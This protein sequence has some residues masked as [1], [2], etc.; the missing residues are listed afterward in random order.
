[1]AGNPTI[2][3]AAAVLTCALLSCAAAFEIG[4]DWT[5]SDCTSDKFTT[6]GQYG[7]MVTVP[8]PTV[9]TALGIFLYAGGA[10]N[11]WGFALYAVG[12]DNLPSTLLAAPG[13]AAS[14]VSAGRHAVSL[15]QPYLAAPGNY[16]IVLS[17]LKFNNLN[18][19]HKSVAGGSFTYSTAGF[20]AWSDPYG[21]VT[22]VT[23]N[24]VPG[25]YLVGTAAPTTSTGTTSTGT[26]STGT[27]STGTTSTG[28]T[29]TGTTSTGTTSTGTTST[30]VIIPG[31]TLTTNQRPI[32]YMAQN[33]ETRGWYLRDTKLPTW[34]AMLFNTAVQ[35]H[36]AKLCVF[37]HRLQ[38]GATTSTFYALPRQV[39]VV[40]Y[41][42]DK[43]VGVTALVAFGADKPGVRATKVGLLLN[44]QYQPASNKCTG[45]EAACALSTVAPPN[46]PVVTFGYTDDTWGL[47]QT[48]LTPLSVNKKG[49][50]VGIA[51]PN[52]GSTP[53]EVCINYVHI[54]VHY[55]A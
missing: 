20:F 30:G 8:T 22:I 15:D 49:F 46:D 10:A 16:Y 44:G 51:A 21:P 28:T 39:G 7:V 41:S 35:Q 11:L 38:P 14:D 25:L 26:T 23:N 34:P 40:P 18:I 27:T 52:T 24:V 9:V 6:T 13:N 5:L 2:F 48:A 43:V 29:S 45:S 32:A 17:F 54:A 31:C 36:D 12:G 37:S 55:C 4:A 3:T 50:G 47:S 19:C 42:A 33:Y 1:M 53:V